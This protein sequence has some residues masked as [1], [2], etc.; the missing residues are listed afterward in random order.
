MANGWYEHG[1][2]AFANGLVD[3]VNDTIRVIAVNKTTPGATTYTPDLNQHQTLSDVT[4]GAVFGGAPSNVPNIFGTLASKTTSSGAGPSFLGGVL[5]AADTIIA[6]LTATT[7]T[8]DSLIIYKWVGPGAGAST[9]LLYI[10][11][12]TGLTTP[13]TA[14]N[15]TDQTIIWPAAGIAKV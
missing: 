2:D 1:L 13:G 11:T 5:D 3:W 14:P 9:L 8:I 7:D 12:G 4:A 10:D 6:G 15:G